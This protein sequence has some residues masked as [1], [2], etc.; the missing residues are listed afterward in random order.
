MSFP[1]ALP[2]F[3]ICLW[4]IFSQCVEERM[5][6]LI[7]SVIRLSKQV[8]FCFSLFTAPLF[9]SSNLFQVMSAS[10]LT[11]VSKCVLAEF[12]LFLQ[13]VDIEKPRHKT[14]ITS[15]VRQ[16]IMLTNRKAR[17]E[18][19]KKQA[20]TEKSQKPNEVSIQCF[21]LFTFVWILPILLQPLS[22]NSF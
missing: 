22:V 19:E 7:S 11:Q 12:V 6:E 3:L 4:N 15:D 16:Q 14:V 9:L 10:F 13:R 18:W 21:H 1:E 5:R 2:N 20:E 8:S 17:E